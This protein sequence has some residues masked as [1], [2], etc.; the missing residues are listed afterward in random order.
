M[1][2]TD[3]RGSAAIQAEIDWA[4]SRLRHISEIIVNMEKE[5]LD[6]KLEQKHLDGDMFNP[7][8]SIAR[9]FGEL[10][11]AKRA[12]A[13]RAAIEIRWINPSSLRFVLEKVTAKQIRIRVAGSPR[14]DIYGLNGRM[15]SE[16]SGANRIDIRATFGLD[17]DE[18]PPNF[19][20][21]MPKT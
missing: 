8:G 18:V 14:I 10:V 19:K 12:E 11:A 1:S 21:T 7:Q 2:D 17:A 5:L 16:W 9:L 13:D 3:T 6:L 4:K 20:P 15:S